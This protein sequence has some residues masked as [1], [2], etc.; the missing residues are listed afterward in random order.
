MQKYLLIIIYLKLPRL[1][2]IITENKMQYLFEIKCTKVDF[3][4]ILWR[5][6]NVRLS[7]AQHH[8]A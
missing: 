1:Y 6:R 5:L 3:F 2:Y 7:E 4:N 8:W